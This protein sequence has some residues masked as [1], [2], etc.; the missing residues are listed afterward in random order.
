MLS[1]KYSSTRVQGPIANAK[2]IV[3]KS[4]LENSTEP[5]TS[6]LAKLKPGVQILLTISSHR[7]ATSSILFTPARDGGKSALSSTFMMLLEMLQAR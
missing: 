3:S 7:L 5:Q 2:D 1:E 4:S 6:R